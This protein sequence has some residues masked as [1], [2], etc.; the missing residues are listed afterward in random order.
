MKTYHVADWSKFYENN[1]SRRISD[2]RWVPIP[3]AHD[4]EK[5]T[6][7]ISRPD[8]PEIFAAWI[9]IL[10]VASRCAVRG[11]LVRSNGHPHD[12]ASLSLKTRAPAKLFE[13]ALSYLEKNGW[14]IME[15]NE[16]PELALERQSS[17]AKVTL[18]AH[19]T[20]E[21]WNGME[22]IEKKGTGAVAPPFLSEN[23]TKAWKEWLAYRTER[24]L[25]AYKPTSIAAQFKE[26][27]SWGET[28]AVES[29]KESIRNQ[30]QGLFAPK[31]GKPSQRPEASVRH[32]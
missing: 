22:G 12:S 19:P 17:D 29:I 13:K 31:A 14:L 1:R 20:D 18:P 9:L 8:G 28:A 16:Q 26:L 30:W 21:E 15:L 4:G 32:V 2:L 11:T 6:E 7:L 24:K 5:Y 3:N 25:P 23:F 10:Q 27:A